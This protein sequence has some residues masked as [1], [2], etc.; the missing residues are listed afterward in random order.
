MSKKIEDILASFDAEIQR[1][2]YTDHSWT[3]FVL[4]GQATREGLKNWAIQKYHQT[5][6]QIPIFSILHART[7]SKAIRLFMVD[8]LIDEE[9]S[10]SSGGDAHYELMK[11]FAL[12]MG[13]TEEEI[14]NT[15]PGGPVQRYVDEIKDVCWTEHP[16]VVL[17]AMYAG[18]SQTAEVITQVLQKLRDQFGLT[19]HALEWFEVHAGDDEHADAERVLMEEEGSDLPNLEQDGLRVIDRFMTQWNHLQDYY[20]AITTEPTGEKQRLAG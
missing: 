4:S 14:A 18:E 7:D 10:I 9:T 8:Q 5:Y 3:K 12:E 11:R 16:V 15:P 2:K 20:Y 17:A 13:A 19:D 6:L 1:R